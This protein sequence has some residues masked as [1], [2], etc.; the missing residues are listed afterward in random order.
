MNEKG[1]EKETQREKDSRRQAIQ[2]MKLFTVQYINTL[3]IYTVHSITKAMLAFRCW[4]GHL[5]HLSFFSPHSIF[6]YSHFPRG[7]YVLMS[8]RSIGTNPGGKSKFEAFVDLT[9]DIQ[10]F[11]KHPDEF[12][13]TSVLSEEETREANRLGV[14]HLML[15]A[16]VISEMKLADI[17]NRLAKLY[18]EDSK[19]VAGFSELKVESRINECKSMPLHVKLKS[20]SN[21]L[22]DLYR[23][24][25]R[26]SFKMRVF[27][28]MI[29][30]I[31]RSEAAKKFIGIEEFTIIVSACGES[32]DI[33]KLKE[34]IEMMEKFEIE[35]DYPFRIGLMEASSKIGDV[36][37]FESIAAKFGFKNEKGYVPVAVNYILSLYATN[38]DLKGISRTYNRLVLDGGLNPRAVVIILK[39]F[40]FLLF[41][42]GIV[43]VLSACRHFNL[44]FNSNSYSALL[45]VALRDLDA[46]GAYNIYERIKK[47]GLCVPQ[48]I[49]LMLSALKNFAK[50][51]L[52]DRLFEDYLELFFAK[53]G[54]AFAH[55]N[56]SL[57][58]LV[59]MHSIY[60]LHRMNDKALFIEKLVAEISGPDILQ[61][62]FRSQFQVV[63]NTANHMQIRNFFSAI[64]SKDEM[65]RSKD[66]CAAIKVCINEL[67]QLLY[68][69]MCATGTNYFFTHATLLQLAVSKSASVLPSKNELLS[70]FTTILVIFDQMERFNVI[71]T[72]VSEVNLIRI[73]LAGF[74]IHIV[75]MP[76]FLSLIARIKKFVFARV[77]EASYLELLFAYS[78]SRNQEFVHDIAEESFQTFGCSN[79]F[80]LALFNHCVF[81]QLFQ[82][83]S[84]LF[85]VLLLR[86]CLDI[87]AV[88]RMMSLCY[89]M[90][91]IERGIWIY[92]NVFLAK[93]VEFVI[94]GTD[95]CQSVWFY[96]PQFDAIKVLLLLCNSKYFLHGENEFKKL[97]GHKF[98]SNDVADYSFGS[99]QVNGRHI[100]LAA[101][102][103]SVGQ[104][105]LQHGQWDKAVFYFYFY[106]RCT[107][108]ADGIKFY[109]VLQYLISTLKNPELRGKWSFWV[110]KLESFTKYSGATTNEG[111]NTQLWIFIDN[112]FVLIGEH[113]LLPMVERLVK[114]FLNYFKSLR[115]EGEKSSMWSIRLA[116][117]VYNRVFVPM[118]QIGKLPGIINFFNSM[119]ADG[120]FEKAGISASHL[121]FAKKEEKLSITFSNLVK[122]TKTRDRLRNS[123]P[124]KGY[125]SKESNLLFLKKEPLVPIQDPNFFAPTQ[126]GQKKKILPANFNLP[127]KVEDASSNHVEVHDVSLLKIDHMNPTFSDFAKLN[128]NELVV[129]PANATPL[130]SAKT[131]LA[132][133][134]VEIDIQDLFSGLSKKKL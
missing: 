66:C 3:D 64:K 29:E 40:S 33:S 26:P 92:E 108:D 39:T 10:Y 106:Q 11:E 76:E 46:A 52:L 124:A 27:W 4:S 127:P 5:R 8:H 103:F 107:I 59:D 43:G 16:Q 14:A 101:A 68:S 128:P 41:R 7:S 80:L 115:V 98:G 6:M 99:I 79:K 18:M 58:M 84:E 47:Y 93:K 72:P 100:Q 95:K 117:L 74:L 70:P 61:I 69:K 91:A 30:A 83:A 81:F 109:R 104:F 118:I 17:R 77:E 35:M 44:P 125:E 55:D 105:C 24:R 110:D 82:A 34:I 51:E 123:Q 122:N 53:S 13:V 63:L 114:L 102:S 20:L 2:K 78:L 49:R 120:F 73:F 62:K 25:S 45:R 90:N 86:N 113:S 126:Q 1:K 131:N 75:A 67:Y 87:L 97:I 31:P 88:A 65:V 133:N 111:F 21:L 19:L 12:Q 112:I 94:K 60:L 42:A 71:P 116:K 32:H 23:S 121:S 50:I 119:N 56:L 134:E 96:P 37:N 89:D 130:H 132:K 22:K 36:E 129:F 38:L 15:G 48:T 57:N 28:L 9:E 54:P 85:E